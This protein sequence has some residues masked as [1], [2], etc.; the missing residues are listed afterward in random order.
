MKNV[1]NYK[2]CADGRF[3]STDIIGTSADNPNH[4]VKLS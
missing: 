4:G 1:K 3:Q 2:E